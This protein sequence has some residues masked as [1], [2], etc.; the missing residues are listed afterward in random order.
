[1]PSDYGGAGERTPGAG[2]QV[3]RDEFRAGPAGPTPRG[4]AGGVSVTGVLLGCAVAVLAGFAVV[5][6][7]VVALVLAVFASAA[8]GPAYAG[9]ARRD[10]QLQEL[11]VSGQHGDPKVA[12]IPIRGLL[13]PGGGSLVGPDPAK[14]LQAMLDAAREDDRV[15]A[16]MLAV[17]SPG[18]GI[19][20]CDVMHRAVMEYRNETK[21]PVVVLME[22]TAASGAYYVSCAAD[23]IIAHPTTVT[24]SIGVIMPLWDASGLLK[25]VGVSD[26]TVK[27]GEFKDMGSPF[28]DK[29]PEQR[30]REKEILDQIIGEMHA[31]F[32]R[33]VA[34]G[35]KLD[36]SVVRKLADGRIYTS[37]EAKDRK[38]IDETGYEADAVQKAMALAGLESAHVVEYSRVRSL[39]EMLFLAGHDLDLTVRL[40][41]GL[42]LQAE[43]RL[44]YLWYPPAALPVR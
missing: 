21:V 43:P 8:G 17:D 11:T 9:L 33:V 16:V 37:E 41:G 27:S 30:A 28:A 20:T 39:R 18:G 36:A 4:G 22:D 1:M 19:T 15:K 7:I 38:L 2:A 13:M 6:L 42:P 32:V 3:V 26:R 40:D 12:I 24:G 35:R 34:E 25:K 14:V 31:R 44:M 10:V 23:Y 29:T 5:A